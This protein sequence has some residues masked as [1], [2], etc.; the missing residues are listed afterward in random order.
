MVQINT[1]KMAV[2]GKIV[3]CGAAESGKNTNLKIIH[4]KCP[5][6]ED[7]TT[8]PVSNELGVNYMMTPIDLGLVGGVETQFR[9]F[10]LPGQIKKAS[11]RQSLLKEVDGVVFVADSQIGRLGDNLAAF[12]SLVADLKANNITIDQ[13]PIIIQYNKRDLP[14]VYPVE[15]LQ[16]KLNR[17][18]LEHVRASTSTG[19]GVL[20]TLNMII[21]LVHESLR[22]RF[23][24]LT[25]HDLAPVDEV[26]LPGNEVEIT[27][28]ARDA[29][30]PAIQQTPESEA[31]EAQPAIS[32]PSAPQAPMEMESPVAAERANE[33]ETGSPPPQRGSGG[34]PPPYA[35]K[36]VNEMDTSPASEEKLVVMLRTTIDLAFETYLD[37]IRDQ[38]EKQQDAIEELSKEVEKLKA[39]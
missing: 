2:R 20:K 31:R 28:E 8:L 6:S 12:D 11:S 27:S 38:I 24:M 23:K 39:R 5:A 30:N 37:P 21:R 7:L 9:L 25:G 1:K 29:S 26:K 34:L 16:N 36:A 14:T 4:E 10:S 3:Y 35:A 18:K 15:E 33:P 19:D 13:I 32:M 22:G 17:H